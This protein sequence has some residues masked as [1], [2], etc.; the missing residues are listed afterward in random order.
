MSHLIRKVVKKGNQHENYC[1]DAILHFEIDNFVFIACFDGCS[2][3]LNSHFASELLSKIMRKSIRTAMNLSKNEKEIQSEYLSEIIIRRTF[4]DLFTI[5]NFLE[6]NDFEILSTIVFAIIDLNTNS[7][8]CLISGDGLIYVDGKKYEKISKDNMPD[9]LAYYTNYNIPNYRQSIYEFK[10][11]NVKDLS[12][13]SDGI[14]SFVDEKGIK[15]NEEFI[16][17]NLLKDNFLSK[18][19]A[20]LSRKV[21]IIQKNYSYLHFDDLSIVRYIKTDDGPKI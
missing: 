2:G 13:C 16:F 9:Y 4:V 6:I 19:E 7:A 11:E 5:K 18:S 1:E 17:E 20:M 21:N 14:Q 10:V 15:V 3:G 12:V 8:Y